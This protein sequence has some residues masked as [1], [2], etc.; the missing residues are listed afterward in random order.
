MIIL[1]SVYLLNHWH[2]DDKVP[3][4][5]HS[6]GNDRVHSDSSVLLT[7]TSADLSERNHQRLQDPPR[8]LRDVGDLSKANQSPNSSSSGVHAAIPRFLDRT[9]KGWQA[10]RQVFFQAGAEGHHRMEDF[11]LGGLGPILITEDHQEL[12]EDSREE[13]LE[14]RGHRSRQ[15]LDQA[16]DG[17]SKFMDLPKVTGEFENVLEIVADVAA[18]DRDKERELLEVEVSM[19]SSV[20]TTSNRREG[21]NDLDGEIYTSPLEQSIYIIKHPPEGGIRRI[22]SPAAGRSGGRL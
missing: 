21:R 16:D 10:Q 22:S 5:L 15:R 20:R 17:E 2:E 6:E 12:R 19:F 11:H 9:D 1:R 18:D 8:V 4:Q 14:F 7:S 3:S 13:A